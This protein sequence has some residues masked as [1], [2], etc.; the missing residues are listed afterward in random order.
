VLQG[1]ISRPLVR[2]S[3][4]VRRGTLLDYFFDRTVSIPESS[5][6]FQN[7]LSFIYPDK[8]PTAFTS[9]DLLLPVLSAANKYQMRVVIDALKAQ[10][11]SRSINGNTYREA[12]LYDDPLKVY[13]KAKEFDLGDLVNAAA[14]A[15]LNVDITLVPDTSSDLASMPAIWLWQ[16]LNTRKER[17]DWLLKKCGSQFYIGSMNSQYKYQYGSDVF[18]AF[19]CSC[20]VG[21]KAISKGIPVSLL[22]KIKAYPCP[23]AIRKIDFNV[24]LSCLRCGAAATA[25]FNRI[26][27]EYEGAFG[28]F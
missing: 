19:R 11:M 24:E 7:L 2:F 13:V 25:Y 21:D 22:D 15:T 16:L 28:M 10:I 9:L 27:N 18:Q 1:A 26:C 23:K 3:A 6:T 4:A 5:E 8:T 12:L 14:N 17:T 20:G